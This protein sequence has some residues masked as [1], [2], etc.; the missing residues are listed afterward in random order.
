MMERSSKTVAFM[1]LSVFILSLSVTGIAQADAE[2][3]ARIQKLEA[4]LEALQAEIAEL[5]AEKTKESAPVDQAL[6]DTMVAEAVKTQKESIS[7]VPD[8]VNRIKLS[9]DFR[10][11]HESTDTESDNR[12]IKGRNR[13]RIRGRL[14]VSAQVTDEWDVFFRL[15][16][17]SADPV[18]SNQTL[19]ESFSTKDFRLDRAYFD[20]HPNAVE[21]L[22]IFGGKMKN[23]FYTPLKTELIWDGDLNPEGIAAK[24]VLPLSDKTSLTLDGGGFWVQYDKYDVDLSLWGAQTILDHKLDDKSYLRGGVSY[25]DYG[26]IQGAASL[27]STFDDGSDFFGNTSTDDDTFANDYNLLELFG[28]Y[29]F[30]VGSMPFALTGDYVKNTAADSGKDTAWLIGCAI[31]KAKDAGSWRARYNYRET[32]ADAVVGL[33]SD[34]DFGGGDTDSKGHEI[35]F[36][37]MI[38]KN[39]MGSLSYFLNEV[40]REDEEIR[41]LQADIIFKF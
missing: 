7:G 10:Y 35:G 8:W 12:W 5:K 34:S 2:T 17:G 22:N 36:D 3:D 24:Y 41:K 29:G 33:F 16:T 20:W 6:I 37:Y 18:S 32:Q 31:N 27:E 15:A 39:V 13:H 21:G 23:P 14:G 19:T 40:G 1:I 28:E 4:A 38:S 26:N 30:K 9:G 25:Y 11:R